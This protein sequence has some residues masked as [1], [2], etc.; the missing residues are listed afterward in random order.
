VALVL[1]NSVASVAYCE[2]VRSWQ[3]S[4]SFSLSVLHSINTLSVAAPGNP[5]PRSR[6]SSVVF[7]DAFTDVAATLLSAHAAD[8]VLP[9]AS[10]LW[11][12][13][14]TANDFKL[15]GSG[16]IQL[17]T[18]STSQAAYLP[19][20]CPQQD[21]YTAQVDIDFSASAAN[22]DFGGIQVRAQDG[23][24]YYF[25]SV[26]GDGKMRIEKKIANVVT[27]IQADTA[28]SL[29]VGTMKVVATMI[30]STTTQLD[31]YWNNVLIFSKQDASRAFKYGERVGLSSGSVAVMTFANFSVT[32]GITSGNTAAMYDGWVPLVGTTNGFEQCQVD[33]RTPLAFNV[34]YNEPTAGATHL[35]TLITGNTK[36]PNFNAASDNLNSGAN[37]I[38]TGAE[39]FSVLAAGGIPAYNT[40]YR[41]YPAAPSVTPWQPMRF[42][43]GG[44]NPTTIDQSLNAKMLGDNYFA[45]ANTGGMT[46]L[47]PTAAGGT[48]GGGGGGCPDEDHR[49]FCPTSLVLATP[50]SN[51]VWS[52]VHTELGG[53]ACVTP[54]HR[55]TTERGL[56]ASKDLLV[57]KDRIK[58]IMRADES[59]RWLLVISEQREERQGRAVNVVVPTEEKLYFCGAPRST[60]DL[61]GHN[62]KP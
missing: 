16:K 58:V 8:A 44:V 13:T 14:I 27:V 18:A 51:K 48:G 52:R 34:A 62:L 26:R 2:M 7:S 46:A 31:C 38:F 42:F 49:V 54:R 15:N 22:G 37:S 5:V 55:W 50:F 24:N 23:N 20:S 60:C 10:N 17:T 11:V 56:V 30:N 29:K 1:C 28:I 9:N 32:D 57:G 6:S 41:F 4:Q 21:G 39:T 19:D 40:T 36:G 35:A 61:E 45:L 25:I 43:G 47:T 53:E 12:R 3:L 33:P 59:V